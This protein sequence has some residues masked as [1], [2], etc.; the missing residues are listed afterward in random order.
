[1]AGAPLLSIFGG[2][3]TTYRKL[4]EEV[5]DRLAPLLGRKP[6]AWTAGVPL[7]GGDLPGGSFEAFLGKAAQRWPWL[8]PGLLERMAR[9]Y[10]TRVERLL[11]DAR[12]IRD[13]GAEVIAG[14][15]EREIEYLRSEEWAATS[16]DILWRRSKLGL[17]RQPGAAG[18]LDD[19]LAGHPPPPPAGGRNRD[20][21]R[22]NQDVTLCA[23]A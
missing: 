23:G 1:M 17:G 15:Y 22:G 19:W 11:A 14:L 18:Q 6:P 13:L 16:E 5:V 7:P 9:A 10:G 12:D 3:L 4:A 8:P 20:S 2:K 21:A